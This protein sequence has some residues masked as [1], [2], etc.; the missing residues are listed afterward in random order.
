M[1]SFIAFASTAD[2]LVSGGNNPAR[3]NRLKTQKSVHKKDKELKVAS[4]LPCWAYS[5]NEAIKSPV[6]LAKLTEYC[7]SRLNKENLSFILDLEKFKFCSISKMMKSFDNLVKNYILENSADSIN[8]TRDVRK[9]ILNIY[10]DDDKSKITRNVFEYAEREILRLLD[11][12]IF[13][14]FKNTLEDGEESKPKTFLNS[15]KSYLSSHGEAFGRG[16]DEKTPKTS[17]SNS[18]STSLKGTPVD[19]SS[20]PEEMYNFF[21]NFE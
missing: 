10:K 13:L 7:E 1:Y 6:G 17:R 12:D 18:P 5:L 19:G 15:I 14:N 4:T 9:N 3:W 11:D 20:I 2:P 16:S 8:I 21:N